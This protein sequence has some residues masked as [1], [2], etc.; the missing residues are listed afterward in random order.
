MDLRLIS[1]VLFLRAAWRK[2]D[3]WDAA[4][5]AAQVIQE[6]GKL[7]VLLAGLTPGSSLEA[8]RAGMLTA[9]SEARAIQTGLDVRIVD[10]LE[11]TALGKAPFVRGMK[12]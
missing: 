11:R 1:R 10:Q 8:V 3:H 9:L 5:I 6:P 4:R 2:R 12:S 7:R